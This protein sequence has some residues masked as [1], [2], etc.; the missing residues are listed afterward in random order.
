MPKFIVCREAFKPGVDIRI[1]VDRIVMTYKAPLA[2]EWTQDAAGED[3]PTRTVEALWIVVDELNPFLYSDSRAN[4]IREVDP[5]RIE[6]ILAILD[7][8]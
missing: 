5:E 6:Q 7:A 8:G 4:H 1:N 2:V 3:I